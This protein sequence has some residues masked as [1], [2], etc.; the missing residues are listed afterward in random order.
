[1]LRITRALAQARR[2]ARSVSMRVW[3]PS[4]RMVSCPRSFGDRV[5]FFMPFLIVHF[6][7]IIV[8]IIRMAPTMPHRVAVSFSL[9]GICAECYSVLTLSIRSHS[10]RHPTCPLGPVSKNSILV[11]SFSLFVSLFN[12]IF[13]SYSLFL[14]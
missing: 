8:A 3:A 1:M 10:M 5:S 14:F 7:D 4:L 2:P 11:H 13:L 9:L 12:Y 6:G